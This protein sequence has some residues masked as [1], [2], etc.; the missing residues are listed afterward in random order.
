M[1]QLVQCQQVELV[2]GERSTSLEWIARPSGCSSPENGRPRGAPGSVG[3]GPRDASIAEIEKGSSDKGNS[4]AL[5][6]S[7]LQNDTAASLKTPRRLSH[8]L[9]QKEHAFARAHY[10]E[11][12]TDKRNTRVK[13]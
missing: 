3:H 2:R 11:Q 10:P 6:N 5:Q 8:Y 12:A 4:T 7:T 13:S 1:R 9:T